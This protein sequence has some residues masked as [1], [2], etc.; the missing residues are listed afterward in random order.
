MKKNDL[1]ISN[2]KDGTVIDH[3][4][5][6]QALKILKALD[7]DA[8]ENTISLGMRLKSNSLGKKD[9]IKLEEKELSPLQA[10]QLA[11]FAPDATISIIRNWQV[12]R[13][14]KVAMPKVL[15]KVLSCPNQ[16][17]ISQQLGIDSKFSV[18]EKQTE[19]ELS[20]HYCEKEFLEEEMER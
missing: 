14:F 1:H 9:I 15:K 11:I 2:I 8:Q 16:A 12:Q 3:I 17:C 7:L 4:A 19:A 10:N 20:C 6:G 5:K 18:R 13:S